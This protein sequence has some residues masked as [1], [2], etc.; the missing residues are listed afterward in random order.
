MPID[1]NAPRQP[2]PPSSSTSIG[3]AAAR[4]GRI[5]RTDTSRRRRVARGLPPDRQPGEGQRGDS[6]EDRDERFDIGAFHQV[7]LEDGGIPLQ[8]LEAKVKDWIAAQ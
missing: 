3:T 1:P 4:A 6:E 5:R 8:V 7:V 2:P